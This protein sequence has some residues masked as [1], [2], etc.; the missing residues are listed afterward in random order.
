MARTTRTFTVAAPLPAVE[1]YLADPAHTADW[2]VSIASLTEATDAPGSWDVLVS[3]YGKRLPF[4]LERGA[5]VP[6]RVVEYRGRHSSAS[7]LERFELT[8]CP[9]GGT[10]ITYVAEVRL[11]GA[12]RLLNKGLDSAFAAVKSKSVVRLTAALGELGATR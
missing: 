12:L 9:D 2:D 5:S 1:A 11:L 6:G 7:S 10:A 3:F 4:R 8:A